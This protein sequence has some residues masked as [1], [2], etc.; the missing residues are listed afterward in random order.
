M[1]TRM[2]QSIHD[3][4]FS[5]VERIAGDW[6]LGLSARLVFSSV[7]L[8]FFL[9]S[10]MTKLGSG[11]SGL[12]IP[13]AKAYAQILPSIAESVS[14]DTEQIA[15]I[16]WGL[17]VFMGTYAEMILPCLI[18]VGLFTR[19]ASLAMIGFIAVMS[20]VDVRFH[21]LDAKSVGSL[22]DRMPDAIISDQRLMW[23]FPLIYLV[24]RGAGAVSLDAVL[25]RRRG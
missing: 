14:Y 13:G 9:N 7:L 2:L 3:Q 19:L 18:L 21:G 17:I 23:V 25:A 10:A 5:M 16:P 22:F 11:F 15:F 6:F 8:V 20:F 12:F 4:V 24:V 1:F